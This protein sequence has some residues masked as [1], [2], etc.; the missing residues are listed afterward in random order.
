[1]AQK[2]PPG[3][4]HSLSKVLSSWKDWAG[5]PAT[6]PVL[7][8]QLGGD[9]NLSFRVTDGNS[10]WAVRLNS[11]FADEGRNL[12]SEIIAHEAACHKG[13]APAIVYYNVECLI[14][15]F[16]QGSKP[17]LEDLPDIGQLF[18]LIHSVDVDIQAL[19]LSGHL[20]T[21]FLQARPDATITHCFNK[22]LA[23][24]SMESGNRVLCHQ[25]LTLENMIHTQE[26]IVTIDWEYASLSDPAFDLAVF[27]HSHELDEKQL[28]QLLT[29]YDGNEPG[30]PSRIHYFEMVYGMI[31]ILWWQ[32]RGN[33]LENKITR[34]QSQLDAWYL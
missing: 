1:M 31:E 27:T 19:D 22:L 23:I 6:K 3:I 16:L 26:R 30:L 17:G 29:H 28:S 24:P 8:S 13:I 11:E 5:K 10:D 20:K 32:I 21:Y 25:D 34:L 7:V 15:E 2:L 12:Q 18:S 4:D 33:R 9:T 14:T